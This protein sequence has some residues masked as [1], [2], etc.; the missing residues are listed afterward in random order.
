[1]PGI[2]EVIGGGE[3]SDGGNGTDVIASYPVSDTQWLVSV[4]NNTGN[5]E[6]V[7]AYAICANVTG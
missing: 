4:F 2:K 3:L 5:S 6:D 1:M 7:W